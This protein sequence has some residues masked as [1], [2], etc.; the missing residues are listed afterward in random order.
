M[1]LFVGDST[2]GQAIMNASFN[3]DWYNY[4]TGWY[5]ISVGANTWVFAAAPGYT[6]AWIDSDSYTYAYLYL[7]A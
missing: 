6:S 7:A 3:F 2:S 1:Y 5:Y 4:G